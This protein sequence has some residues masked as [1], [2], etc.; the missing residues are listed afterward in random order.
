LT[1]NVKHYKD[2]KYSLLERGNLSHPDKEEKQKATFAQE[3]FK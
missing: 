3:S 2:T 1:S